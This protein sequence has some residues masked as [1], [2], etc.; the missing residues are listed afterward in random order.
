M[1]RRLEISTTAVAGAAVVITPEI[2]PRPN[3]PDAGPPR[4]MGCQ[5][6]EGEPSRTDT[7]F[8]GRATDGGPWC[9]RHRERVYVQR[10]N[11]K[12]A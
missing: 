11:G 8:C 7:T 5:W 10:E 2:N 12:A 6:I 1:L 4:R 3:P 9:G